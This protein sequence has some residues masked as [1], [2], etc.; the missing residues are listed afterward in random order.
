MATK[1]RKLS[2]EN[3]ESQKIKADPQI[4]LHS[5]SWSEV[6]EEYDKKYP[7]FGSQIHF[8]IDVIRQTIKDI[9]RK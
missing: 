6:R 1:S 8:A 4:S 2:R 5:G 3:T 7:L 9:R